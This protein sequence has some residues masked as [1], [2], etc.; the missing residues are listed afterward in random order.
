MAKKHTSSISV[1]AATFERIAAAAKKYG[2]TKADVVR[3][4]CAGILATEQ[5]APR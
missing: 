3:E 4:A 1:S 5:S 2:C